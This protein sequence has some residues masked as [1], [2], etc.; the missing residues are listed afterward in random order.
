[1]KYLLAIL[2]LFL[3]SGCTSFSDMSTM[4]TAELKREYDMLCDKD[5]EGY[6]RW[7]NAEKCVYRRADLG[8]EL[9]E[10]GYYDD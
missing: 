2:V 1:M 9:Y 5:V 10:R 3:F 4:S 8:F 6:W 7:E